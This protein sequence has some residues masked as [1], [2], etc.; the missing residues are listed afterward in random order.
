M[1]TVVIARRRHHAD[2]EGEL[3]QLEGP[4]AM[5]SPKGRATADG[6]RPSYWSYDGPGEPRMDSATAEPRPP[7]AA[8]APGCL[9]A[10]IIQHERADEARLESPYLPVTSEIPELT[11]IESAFLEFHLQAMMEE[12]QLGPEPSGAAFA[13]AP[14]AARINTGSFAPEADLRTIILRTIIL[15][16]NHREAEVGHLDEADDVPTTAK[17]LLAG[18]ALDDELFVT[19]GRASGS[20]S[21]PSGSEPSVPVAPDRPPSARGSGEPAPGGF[22]VAAPNRASAVEAGK[23]KSVSDGAAAATGTSA[24]NVEPQEDAIPAATPAPAMFRRRKSPVALRAVAAFACA[25]ALVSVSIGTHRPAPPV[26]LPPLPVVTEAASPPPPPPPRQETA[27]PVQQEAAVPARQEAVAPPHQEA[28]A[29]PHPE[30]AA[31]PTR[32]QRRLRTRKPPLRPRPRRS[33]YPSSITSSRRGT[34]ASRPAMSL[35]RACSTSARPM[36]EA[37]MPR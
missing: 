8:Y 25:A 32:K 7:D 28:V 14:A 16:P 26:V 33:L 10:S 1:H 18:S 34:S 29:P 19:K 31:P 20:S 3:A 21:W 36:R 15:R 23:I 11:S 37:H 35:R 30:A 9:D 27:A 6:F 5:F 13:E 22:D 12:P 2:A 17:G 24:A 4:A